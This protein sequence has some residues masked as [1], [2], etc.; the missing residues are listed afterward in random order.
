MT[1]EEFER[2][3][4]GIRGMFD[5]NTAIPAGARVTVPYEGTTV[6]DQ[7]V[8]PMTVRVAEILSLKRLIYEGQQLGN[9]LQDNRCVRSTR[10]KTIGASIGAGP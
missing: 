2:N 4:V 5:E 9:C 7:G 1:E 8:G 6:F 3:P 10:P